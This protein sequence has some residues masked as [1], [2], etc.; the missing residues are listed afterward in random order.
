MSA[1]DVANRIERMMGEFALVNSDSQDYIEAEY[2]DCGAERNIVRL[3]DNL[4]NI[5][6]EMPG[7]FSW[8]NLVF[9]EAALVGRLKPGDKVR[10]YRVTVPEEKA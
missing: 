7:Y 8:R 9:G 4:S 10:L 6:V 5:V 3:R 2:V 1:L